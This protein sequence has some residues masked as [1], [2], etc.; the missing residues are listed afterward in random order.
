MNRVE[1]A[2]RSKKKRSFK[3]IIGISVLILLLLIGIAAGTGYWFVAK[4]KP[5]I[6][7]T[8][9]LSALSD[10]V[11]VY[12]DNM[13]VP[14][15]EA[16]NDLDLYTAQG[17]VTAQD[18]MFQMDLSRRQASGQLSE[19]IGNAT[20]DNDKYFLTLG[21]RRAAEASWDSYPK[22]AQAIL[23]AY[24]DGVNA[25]MEEAKD[26]GTLP[27]EFR[28][29]GYTPA[30]WTPIDSLTIGK[31]MAF[32]LG[33]HW[34]GQAFRYALLQ[35]FPKDKAMELF[36]TYPKDGATIIPAVSKE[37][38]VEKSLAAAIIPNPENG[39]NNWVVAGSKTDSGKPLLADD[40]HLSLATPSIWYEIH[41]STTDLDVQGVIFAGIPG[42]ILGH[43]KDIAWGVTNVGPDVQDLY[44]EKR[45]PNNEDEFLYKDKWEKAKTY[46]YNIKVK[47]QKDIPYKVTET[48]HGPIISE[49]AGKENKKEAFSLKWT[50]L[51]PSTELLAILQMNKAKN[52]DEFK[53]ALTNFHTPA[54]N[55]VFASTD[56]TIAYRANGLIPIRKKGDSLLPVPGWTDEYEWKGYVPWEELPTLVNPKEGFIS[57]AN[58]KVVDDSYPYHITHHWAQPYRQMRIQ[59]VL[60]A[61][62]KL[63]VKDMQN[64]QMDD[65]NLRAQEL[66]PLLLKDLN[67]S[68]A[69]KTEKEAIALLKDWNYKDDKDEAAPFIFQLWMNQMSKS[70]F[71][72]EL[73]KEMMDLFEGREL[74]LDKMIRQGSTGKEGSWI[75]DA[76]GYKSLL[77]TTFKKA[78]KEASKIQGDNT[79]KWKWGDYHQIVFNHPLSS[80]SPLNLLFN[81]DNNYPA[82]GS[83]TTVQAAGYDNETGEVTHGGSWRGVMDLQDLSESY[84]LVGPGQ[85]GYVWSEWYHNQK[86]AWT[87]GKYH[88]TSTDWNTIKKTDYKLVLTP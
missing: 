64:L 43:N 75:K 1:V 56:G 3:K 8:I 11:S 44:I 15:I 69:T 32:D 29:L 81:G 62:D 31:Y 74:I 88:K 85:S 13:G 30:K 5:I 57:T 37:I 84:H 2:L 55:F 61:G 80:V 51:Q 65:K 22:E 52:W 60:K 9:K 40:P 76:G 27:I 20:V 33:G 79:E 54:Q 68:K 63:T 39:S 38:D 18:R 34:N 67:T 21:L 59:E 73:S 19:L 77:A 4:T 87:T 66:L 83:R 50:A 36:P 14:H 35:K 12:R 82:N 25:Y 47:K 16:K 71:E 58:N 23:Q 45:N 10:K 17:Y 7:G 72:K 53:Q 41:L 6:K 26:N 86:K 24:A 28:I 49:F 48:R 42:I 70:L 78:V 46:T